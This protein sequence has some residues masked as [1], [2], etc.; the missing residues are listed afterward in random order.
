[1]NV[2]AVLMSGGGGQLNAVPGSAFLSGGEIPVEWVWETYIPQGSLSVLSA[3]MKVGKS[4]LIYAMI[5]AIVKGESFCGFPTVK[6]PVLLLAVEEHKREVTNRLLQFGVTTEDPI[7]IHCGPLQPT[8]ATYEGMKKLVR[9]QNVGLIILDTLSRFWMIDD[10]NDNAQVLQQLNPMLEV[11]RESGAA[12]LIVHHNS[13]SEGQA[14]HSGGRAIRGASAIFSIVDQALILRKVNA[15]RDS[16]DRALESDG[17]Y[18]QTP[19]T[20]IVRLNDNA[21]G[22]DLIGFGVD[23]PRQLIADKI[24]RWLEK[25]PGSWTAGQI[26]SAISM[27]PGVVF[28]ALATPQSWFHREGSGVKGKPFVYSATGIGSDLDVPLDIAPLEEASE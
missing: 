5:S 19:L 17:R 4:T 7:F 26:A 11:A 20:T 14:G 22:Y 1:M 13:K 23:A 25:T 24:K 15:R 27:K 28:K 8:L 9:E 18:P 21:N 6:T 10:E 2:G 16:P 12:F 3:F